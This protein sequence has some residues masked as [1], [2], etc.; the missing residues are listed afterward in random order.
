MKKLVCLVAALALCAAVCCPVFAQGST[1]VPSISY[2]D[3]PSLSGA[4][5]NG[6]PLDGCLVITSVAAAQQGTTDVA[7]TARDKL[8]T[9]YQ[10]LSD[11][12]MQ[13]PGADGTLV[14]RELV[15]LSFAQTG[16]I[17]AAHA[18]PEELAKDGTTAAVRFDLDLSALT[19]VTVF[20]YRD[21]VWS[22]V[23]EVVNNGDGTVTCVLEDTGV[24]AFCVEAGAET[25]APQTGDA[26]SGEAVIWGVL[27]VASLAA[28]VLLVAKRRSFL[29]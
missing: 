26:F 8:L 13:L 2:K 27:T 16:C 24:L 28:V 22:Q 29:R 25:P 10:Q 17:G 9:V 12:T 15:D 23:S 18:H 4:E 6:E 19:E 7:Q 21:G 14:I 11:G 1:F 5:L 20:C 3:G